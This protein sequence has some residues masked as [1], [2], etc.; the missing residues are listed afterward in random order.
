MGQ[1]IG[2]D[3]GRKRLLACGCCGTRWQYKRT[4]CPFCDN[5]VRR[6]SVLAIEGEAGLRIDHCEACQGYLKTYD[7]QGDEALLLAD[8][9]SLHLDVLATGRGWK[10]SATSL[11]EL[12]PEPSER[13][14]QPEGSSV[15]PRE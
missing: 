5:D 10:R 1:L 14:G 7:G 2:K 4:Q 8:W 12:P 11:Y 9:S 15:D 3:P 13:V 6:S